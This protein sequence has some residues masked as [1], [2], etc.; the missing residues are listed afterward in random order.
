LRRLWR[1]RLLPRRACHRERRPATQYLASGLATLAALLL[2]CA[3]FD[4]ITTDNATT[5][6]TEYALLLARAGSLTFVAVRLLRA[7]HQLLGGASLLAVAAGFWAQRAI[8]PGIVPGFWAEYVVVTAAYL[9]FVALA[10]SLVWLACR[11]R[12]HEA[13]TFA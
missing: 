9:W 1:A 2:I 6:G 7:G 13:G 8:G 5:F 11:R 10:T 4:D 12:A 3:A